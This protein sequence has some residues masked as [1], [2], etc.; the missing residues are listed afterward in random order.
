MLLPTRVSMSGDSAWRSGDRH[1]DRPYHREMSDALPDHVFA[2]DPSAPDRYVPSA[3]ARGPWDPGAQHGGAPA[4]LLA[5]I[6]DGLDSLVPMR[7]ARLTVELVKPVPLA[8]CTVRTDVIR[9]GKRVQLVD[10]VI[11][12]DGVAVVRARALR[13]R[14]ADFDPLTEPVSLPEGFVRPEDSAPLVFEPGHPFGVG[15]FQAMEM[16]A[17]H[18][19]WLRRGPAAYWF[20]PRVDFIAGEV[21]TPLMQVCAA[22]DFGNGLSNELPFGKYLYINPDLT[23]ALTR[24]PRTEWVLVD[25]RT[26]LE[27]NA[28]GLAAAELYDEAG[29]IGRSQQLLL[30]DGP[31]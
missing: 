5:A 6:I 16:R 14:R 30:I 20:R 21:N 29:P 2:R 18:G 1:A 9:E 8:P 28:S 13:L 15:F 22:A 24:E 12:V 19:D 7:V 25:A 4:A 10:A 23:I 11:E 3:I 17:A 27:T 31:G 26:M